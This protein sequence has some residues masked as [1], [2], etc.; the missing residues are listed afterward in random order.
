[1]LNVSVED[2]E[3]R[4]SWRAFR[5]FLRLILMSRQHFQWGVFLKFLI[6]S[7]TCLSFCMM[8]HTQWKSREIFQPMISDTTHEMPLR[9]RSTLFLSSCDFLF[10]HFSFSVCIHLLVFC[11]HLII[12]SDNSGGKTLKIHV[13]VSNNCHIIHMNSHIT[14][15]LLS[16][17]QILFD[18][19]EA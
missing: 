14:H 19:S 1:M 2:K 3:S 4:G 17:L 15:D 9:L 11:I 8:A 6:S 7:S 5:G 13:I 16:F 18:N 10:T 12:S